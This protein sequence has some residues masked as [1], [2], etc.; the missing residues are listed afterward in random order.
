MKHFRARPV[1]NNRINNALKQSGG[2]KGCQK[3][4]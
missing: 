4:Y 3:G 2:R 1:T